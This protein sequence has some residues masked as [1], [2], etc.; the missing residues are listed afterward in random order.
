MDAFLVQHVEHQSVLGWC[1]VTLGLLLLEY[2]IVDL[3]AELAYPVLVELSELGA[4]RRPLMHTHDEL[5]R[6]EALE[7]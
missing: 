5:A 2:F 1:I 4:E 7:L 3:A 6:E